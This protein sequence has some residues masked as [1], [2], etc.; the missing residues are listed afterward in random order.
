MSRSWENREFSKRL[1]DKDFLSQCC[2]LYPKTILN[3]DLYE[4]DFQVFLRVNQI[5]FSDYIGLYSSNDLNKILTL[6]SNIE[7]ESKLTKFQCMDQLKKFINVDNASYVNDK[8]SK[9]EPR[10][11]LESLYNTMSYLR[12]VDYIKQ[13]YILDISSEEFNVRFS[14]IL[15]KH[16]KGLSTLHDMTFKNKRLT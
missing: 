15:E 14:L 13:E 5:N 3:S 6:K 8:I 11:T 4:I 10:G 12:F 9:L 1:K 2:K 16:L 7:Y